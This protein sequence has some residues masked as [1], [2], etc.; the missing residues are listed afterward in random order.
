MLLEFKITWTNN[1]MS[2]I[3]DGGIVFL[4]AIY[5]FDK[6]PA[7]GFWVPGVCVPR[8]KYSHWPSGA[9]SSSGSQL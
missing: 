7:H 8:S 5:I 3:L 6:G 4:P 2:G 9:G 1:I